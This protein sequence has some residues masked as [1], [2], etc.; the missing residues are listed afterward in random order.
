MAEARVPTS[1]VAPAVATVARRAAWP[2]L[3]RILESVVLIAFL[4]VVWQIVTSSFSMVYFPT[5]VRILHQVITGWL[6]ATGLNQN[7]LPSLVRVTIGWL[8]AAAVGIPLGLVLGLLPQVGDYFRPLVHYAR[9]VPGPVVLPMFMIFLGVGDVMKVVFIAFSV[10]WPIVLNTLKG[11]ESIDLTQIDTARVYQ[12]PW[13]PRL[14][15]VIV[16]AALPDVM[17]GL[18]ISLSMAFIL[19][20]I[21]EMVAASGGI[22]FQI[23]QSQ[24]EFDVVNMW[25][26][27]VILAV[28]GVV[29]NALLSLAEA[30]LLRWHRARH[31]E[32]A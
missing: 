1:T 28:G 3:R 9:S 32:A 13:L 11:V 16:P 18:R 29:F 27:M 5:P 31:R 26:G 14:T 24:A 20:V 19:M 23:L 21:S 8:L 30:R 25:A 6:S 4:V 22:G 2:F 12:I 10:L 15:R 17:A 7:V